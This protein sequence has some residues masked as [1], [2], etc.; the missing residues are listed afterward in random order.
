MMVVRSR[1][2]ISDVLVGDAGAAVALH[3]RPLVADRGVLAEEVNIIG[4]VMSA[5][6][7]L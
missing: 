2:L 1:C 3:R 6:R 7:R 5:A 4:R